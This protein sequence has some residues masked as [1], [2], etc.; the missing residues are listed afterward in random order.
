MHCG[1]A[2]KQN[3]SIFFALIRGHNS[4]RI[5]FIYFYYNFV[6]GFIFCSQNP[7]KG[8][9]RNANDTFSW[10]LGR[11]GKKNKIHNIIYQW[12]S[13]GPSEKINVKHLKIHLNLKHNKKDNTYAVIKTEWRIKKM[14]STFWS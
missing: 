12:F 4:P 11:G 7:R 3:N 13:G 1:I 8:T 14:I 9:C 2:P 5:Y 10:I 6:G